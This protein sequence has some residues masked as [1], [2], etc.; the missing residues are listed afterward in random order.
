MTKQN[1]SSPRARPG[2]IRSVLLGLCLLGVV[3]GVTISLSEAKTDTANQLKKPAPAAVNAMANLVAPPAPGSFAV[4]ESDAAPLRVADLSAFARP[5]DCVARLNTFLSPIFVNFDRGSA[6]ISTQNVDLLTRI[7]E[8]I[9]ACE[10]AYVMVGGHAD[11]SGEDDI[12]LALSWER[13]DRALNILLSLGVD[14]QAV[15]AIGYGA[16][17]PL[18]QGSVD[19]EDSGDRRVDFRVVRR[20]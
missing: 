4:A 14:P 2:L 7:S 13:A 8:E 6:D 18:A 11:G 15:E 17:A 9:T 20:P 12:N 16:R 3:G 1:L 5:Q 10:D 19:D